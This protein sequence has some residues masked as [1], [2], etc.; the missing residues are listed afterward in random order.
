[1]QSTFIFLQSTDL[2]ENRLQVH[3][4]PV[5]VTEQLQEVARSQGTT[6]VVDEFSGR[7]ESVREDFKLLPL[8]EER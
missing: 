6:C 3:V 2:F 8:R 4:E 1:M 5:A 7:W